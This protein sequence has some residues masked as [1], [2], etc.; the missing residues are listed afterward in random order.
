MNGDAGGDSRWNVAKK[1]VETVTKAF[2]GQIRFGLATYSSC[3]AGGCSAGSIVTPI[4]DNNASAINNFL[5]M[6][7]DSG[8]QDG[9]AL[10][11]NGKIR[12]L[13]DS[14]APETS[15]GKALSALVGAPDL[16]DP[17]RANAILL[18]TDGEESDQCVA[19]CNGSC[20]AK[21]LLDQAKSVKT[22]VVGL[23]VNSATIDQIAK[24]GGTNASVSA[25]SQMQLNAAFSQIASEVATC[26]Y[27]LDSRPPDATNLS[28]FFNDVA[29]PLA[30]DDVNGWSYDPG[31]NRVT[32]KG[33][34]CTDIKNGTV[35]DI[36]VVF[37]CPQ[38]VV[39]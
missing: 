22:F 39:L 38:P 11:G 2:D 18:L 37:G 5:A 17:L 16:Q 34:A 8:S 6:T 27:A 32:F 28:V 36:D 31:T 35:I 9:K 25:N 20:G 29:E 12:Y 26:E 15:T 4:A 7:T 3:L 33:K 19:D 30:R 1:A 10:D 23:G 24:A 21:R 14:G 13:C